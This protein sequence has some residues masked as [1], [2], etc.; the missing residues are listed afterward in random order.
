MQW[1]WVWLGVGRARW[2]SPDPPARGK[3]EH[4]ILEAEGGQLNLDLLAVAADKEVVC[5]NVFDAGQMEDVLYANGVLGQLAPGTV[6]I[7]HTTSAPQLAIDIARHAPPGVTVIDG[8]FSGSPQQ[9][10]QGALTVM[11]GG[12]PTV[13]L[14]AEPVLASYASYLRHVGPLGA[15]MRLK[16][17]NNLLFGAQI[18]LVS[19]AFRLARETGIEA[20]VLADIISRSSGASTALSILSQHR[21][22]GAASENM[23]AYL[24]RTSRPRS[25]RLTEK[26]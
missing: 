6:L 14:N 23:R 2:P 17:I 4:R 13:F 16:L 7:L 22:P 9:A 11:A 24:R 25:R 8:A 1:V 21:P 3:P 12:D 20:E 19:D 26:T 5:I 15:G 10:A 18:A